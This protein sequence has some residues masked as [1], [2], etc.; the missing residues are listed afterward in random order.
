MIN[1]TICFKPV[2]HA[3]MHFTYGIHKKIISFVE[4]NYNEDELRSIVNG[5]QFHGILMEKRN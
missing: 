1:N 3:K 4:N 2:T 5:F